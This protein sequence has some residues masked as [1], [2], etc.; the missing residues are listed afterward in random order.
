MTKKQAFPIIIICIRR[1]H[2]RKLLHNRYVTPL[3]RISHF[4]QKPPHILRSWR[5]ISST[6]RLFLALH[7]TI[8]TSPLR[9]STED[10]N[11]NRAL[12]IVSADLL[13]TYTH[14]MLCV[15]SEKCVM[16]P[17]DARHRCSCVIVSKRA[18]VIY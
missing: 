6:S 5:L 17:T 7:V 13:S 2:S 15:I 9:S 14:S 3:Q 16:P 4:L 12:R 11:L 10:A 18:N 8:T 1:F